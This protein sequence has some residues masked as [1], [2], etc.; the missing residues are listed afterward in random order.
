MT[1]GERCYRRFADWFLQQLSTKN[2]IFSR[3]TVKIKAADRE[4]YCH[5]GQEEDAFFHLR[6]ETREVCKDLEDFLHNFSFGCLVLMDQNCP[7]KKKGEKIS[8]C[9]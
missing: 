6:I 2:V 9:C 4:S 3:V 8:A 1:Q 5:I 7:E